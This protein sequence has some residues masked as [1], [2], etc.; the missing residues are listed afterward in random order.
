MPGIMQIQQDQVV[1]VCPVELAHFVRVHRRRDGRIAG[2]AQDGVEQANVRVRSSTPGSVA[3]RMSDALIMFPQSAQALCGLGWRTIIASGRWRASRGQAP[4]PTACDWACAA[5]AARRRRRPPGPGP[6]PAAD[7]R[8]TRSAG[9]I[10]SAGPDGAA[11]VNSIVT[12]SLASRT[13]SSFW[14]CA[15]LVTAA[16]SFSMI[17]SGLAAFRIC[18]GFGSFPQARSCASAFCAVAK[19]PS[20]AALM[21]ATNVHGPL[22]PR[23]LPFPACWAWPRD[24]LAA[25]LGEPRRR[26]PPESFPTGSVSRM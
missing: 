13:A 23:P 20:L 6:R 17:A 4:S 25:A 8:T 2:A 22:S 18:A 7:R 1:P 14:P 5:A 16:T 10:G 24:L 9:L 15:N 11:I 21:P 3:F 19:S 12:A 26:L